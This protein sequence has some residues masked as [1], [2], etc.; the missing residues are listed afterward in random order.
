MNI[1]TNHKEKLNQNQIG[2]IIIIIKD[3]RNMKKS[4]NRKEI[5]E[6]KQLSSQYLTDKEECPVILIIK[7]QSFLQEFSGRSGISIRSNSKLKIK[8]S[9]DVNIKGISPETIE[10]EVEN[11]EE[12]LDNASIFENLTKMNVKSFSKS[13]MR[14]FLTRY[15]LFLLLFLDL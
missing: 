4:R 7:D 13:E 2:I 3:D 9:I 15:P 10:E 5:P 1:L 8:N 6:F 14:L 11:G 12:Q